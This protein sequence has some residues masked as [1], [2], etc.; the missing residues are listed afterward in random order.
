LVLVFFF[1]R[2]VIDR[3][4][5]LISNQVRAEASVEAMKKQVS[6]NT[7][8]YTRVV[9]EKDK[10]EQGKKEIEDAAKAKAEVCT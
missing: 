6:Q 4:A 9:S 10:L 1:F 5:H 2:S 7:Q 8:E 3:I